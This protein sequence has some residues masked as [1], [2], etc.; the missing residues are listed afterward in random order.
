MT[1]QVAAKPLATKPLPSL[2]RQAPSLPPSSPRPSVPRPDGAR[3]REPLKFRPSPAAIQP[4]RMQVVRPVLTVPP[5]SSRKSE[6]VDPRARTI[7]ATPAPAP[8]AVLPT[9]RRLPPPLPRTQP[10]HLD[11]LPD[12]ELTELLDTTDLLDDDELLED[13]DLL[14]EE[15]GATTRTTPPPAPTPKTSKKAWLA[16]VT[17]IVVSAAGVAVALFL[18]SGPIEPS[19]AAAR[20][21]AAATLDGP[22]ATSAAPPPTPAALAAPKADKKSHAHAANKPQPSKAKAKAPRASAKRTKPPAPRAAAKKP[23]KASTKK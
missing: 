16:I 9:P 22:D 20:L 11:T 6:R 8:A 17:G 23:T 19:A 12:A 10:A 5:P 13:A 7:L 15:P 3:S 14:D 2:P 4:P 21:D 18:Q 1:R